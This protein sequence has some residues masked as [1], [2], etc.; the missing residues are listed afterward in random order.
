M[1]QQCLL[2]LGVLHTAPTLIERL[3]QKPEPLVGS[4][5]KVVAA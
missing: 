3:T 1:R 2:G 5:F 4:N